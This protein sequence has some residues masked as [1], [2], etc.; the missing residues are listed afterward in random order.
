MRRLIPFAVAAFALIVTPP[1]ARADT[2][3]FIHPDEFFGSGQCS[4]YNLC[5]DMDLWSAGNASDPFLY[6]LNVSYWYGDG[7]QVDSPGALMA[8]GLFGAS[9]GGPAYSFTGVT[10]VNKKKTT[11]VSTGTGVWSTQCSGLA[12]NVAGINPSAFYICGEKAPAGGFKGLLPGQSATFAFRA[13]YVDSSG[14]KQGLIPNTINGRIHTGG[15]T[16]DGAPCASAKYNALPGSGDWNVGNLG[17]ATGPCTIAPP[18]VTTTPEPMS[19]AL[20]G[21]GLVAVVTV[22]RRRKN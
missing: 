11:W 16:I 17:S 21:T 18:P 22:R 5:V 20:L 19:M 2:D 8:F 4:V 6:Y 14:Q 7:G 10:Q 12:G 15:P 3:P 9:S 13:Y 1:T